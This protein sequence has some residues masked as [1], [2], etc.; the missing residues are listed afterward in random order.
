M[1]LPPPSQPPSL[2]REALMSEVDIVGRLR[3]LDIDQQGD[4]MG[5]DSEHIIS[6]WMDDADAAMADAA[7]EIERLRKERDA[8]R[9]ARTAAEAELARYREALEALG[10][11]LSTLEA[12]IEMGEPKE[13]ITNFVASMQSGL[14]DTLEP[15]P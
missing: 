13:V 4:W 6:K 9:T 12:W 15:K 10:R 14:S 5:A 7:D 2:G 3:A 8:E 11:D 1:R